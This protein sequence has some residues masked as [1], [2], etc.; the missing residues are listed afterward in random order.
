[1]AA[2]SVLRALKFY[3]TTGRRSVSL[4]GDS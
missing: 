4:L 2:C 1:M 3:F